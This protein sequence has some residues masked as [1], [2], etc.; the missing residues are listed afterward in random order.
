MHSIELAQ[1]YITAAESGDVKA[2]F[3]L[4][5]LYANAH[6]GLQK[7]E[8]LAYKWASMAAMNG[9]AEAAML[10]DLLFSQMSRPDLEEA[11]KLIQNCRANAL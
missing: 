1:P 8:K 9:D 5:L 11:R 7:N 4:A 2:Q 6:G 3:T 10:V